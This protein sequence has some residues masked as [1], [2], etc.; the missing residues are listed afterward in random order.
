MWH[1]SLFKVRFRFHRTLGVFLTLVLPFTGFFRT[2]GVICPNFDSAFR[3]ASLF[4]PNMISYAG[5]IIPRDS[6]Q[7]FMEWMVRYPLFCDYDYY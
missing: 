4:V 2:V 3:I 6:M 5:Y 1:S 7:V